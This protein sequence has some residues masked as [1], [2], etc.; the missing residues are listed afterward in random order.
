MNHI[1]AVTHTTFVPSGLAATKDRGGTR[2][3]EV[4]IG[5]NFLAGLCL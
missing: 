3:I 2:R 5:C 4:G 1:S